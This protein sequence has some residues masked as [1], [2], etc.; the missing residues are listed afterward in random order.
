M[1][2]P[3]GSRK[4]PPRARAF[5]NKKQLFEQLL[6]IVLDLLEKNGVGAQKVKRLLKNSKVRSSW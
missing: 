2:K 1:V 5:S 6:A 4:A 3:D